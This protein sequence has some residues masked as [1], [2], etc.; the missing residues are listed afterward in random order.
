[1]VVPATAPAGQYGQFMLRL[2]LP[3]STH[4]QKLSSRIRGRKEA[5]V[6]VCI[7]RV[8]GLPVTLVS[9]RLVAGVEAGH[10]RSVG[11]PVEASG[12]TA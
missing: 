4:V 8:E 6:R 11:G 12:R 7:T 5:H 10:Y 9:R 1:M 2:H 3:N